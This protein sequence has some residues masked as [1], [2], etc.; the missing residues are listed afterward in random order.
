MGDEDGA[1][2]NQQVDI[3]GEVLRVIASL[4]SESIGDQTG[5]SSFFLSIP[6]LSLL[7][8]FSFPDFTPVSQSPRLPSH[9]FLPS[10]PASCILP[11]HAHISARS[12]VGTCIA[13]TLWPVLL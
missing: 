2:P 3:R 13:L 9:P 6:A 8:A 7:S 4:R 10:P 11:S 12:R 1:I 5:G